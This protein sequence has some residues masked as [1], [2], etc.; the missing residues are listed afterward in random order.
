MILFY[1]RHGD[2]IYEPNQLTPLGER[3]AEAV[4]KRLAH[5][6]VDKV[7]ASTSNRAMQTAKPTCELMKLEMETLD[8][9]NEFYAFKE[10]AIPVSE[11]KNRWV[12]AHPKY[13]ALMHSKEMR[14]LGDLWYE[15]PSLK[16]FD[17]GRCQ[18]RVGAEMDAWLQTLGYR[19]DRE[20]GLYEIISEDT[21]KRVA[22]F[23]H[24]GVGKVF[25]SEILDIPYP[26]YA[27]CFEF[28]H[29]GLTAIEFKM[30]PDGKYAFA[31][32]LTLSNDSHLYREGLPLYNHNTT[33]RTKY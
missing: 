3:Q 32:V 1:I 30:L 12:W 9:I 18:K 25:M 22:L 21:D 10:M 6:G 19:H 11:V 4:A 28:Q 23:A 5:Y 15:H 14:E 17:L 33:G 29:T 31:H 13:I 20:K 7:F 27:S 16:E 26:V 2:P 8:W 24:E